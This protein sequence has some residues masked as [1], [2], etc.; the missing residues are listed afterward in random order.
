MAHDGPMMAHLLICQDLPL[1]IVILRETIV[2][3]PERTLRNVTSEV[4]ENPPFTSMI[5]P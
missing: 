5:F 1:K 4:M 2:K 3:L